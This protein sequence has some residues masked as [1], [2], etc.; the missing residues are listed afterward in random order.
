[1]AAPVLEETSTYNMGGVLIKRFVFEAG[2]TA[3]AFSHNGPNTPTFAIVTRSA[4][5]PTASESAVYTLTSTE[6]TLDCEATSGN[7]DVILF[8]LDS[9]SGGLNP[10]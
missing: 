2:N 1:M 5:N 10:P 3:T 9:A 4:T 6:F 8:F 7:V